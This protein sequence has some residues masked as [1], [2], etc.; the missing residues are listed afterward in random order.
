ML[1]REDRQKEREY[2]DRKEMLEREDRQ[3]EQEE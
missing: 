2:Q 1:E 3:K